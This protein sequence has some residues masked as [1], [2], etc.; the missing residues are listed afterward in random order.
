[1]SEWLSL[2][3]TAQKI[4]SGE[5]AA[6]AVV[7]RYLQRIRDV[8]PTVKAYLAVDGER[9]REQ[10]AEIDK[11]RAAGERLP[12]LAGVPI[13]LKDVLVTRDFATTALRPEPPLSRSA[14][15]TWSRK[16]PARV[17]KP[18]PSRRACP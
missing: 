15:R 16:S 13:S 9:A 5:L 4:A 14:V 17:R 11:R 12:R 1:M 18:W 8:D 2:N 7:E 3:E 6:V 10:A